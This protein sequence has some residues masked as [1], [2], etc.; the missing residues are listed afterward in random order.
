MEEYSY[1]EDIM[2]ELFGEEDLD[3]A[4][5]EV[6]FEAWDTVQNKV[7]IRLLNTEWNKEQLEELPHKEIL[8][9][10]AVFYLPML[11]DEKRSVSSVITYSMMKNWRISLKELWDAA[12][13]NTK[14]SEAF[15]ILGVE[16]IVKDATGID[17]SRQSFA[18][19]L[20]IATNTS[21]FY[22]ASALL[23]EDVLLELAERL[24][25]NLYIIPSSIHELVLVPD[26]GIYDVAGMKNMLHEVNAKMVRSY[27]RLSDNIYLFDWKERKIKML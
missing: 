15:R 24:K 17:I 8:D 19:L 22:G 12:I 20:Y 11:N 23:R 14:E 16:D 26:H 21:K 1:L 3:K 13:K 2:N 5:I 18:R 4:D 9:L 25:K 6:L 10:S 27:E 7:L